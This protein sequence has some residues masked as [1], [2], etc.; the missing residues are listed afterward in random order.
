MKNTVMV[1][2]ASSLTLQ[3]MATIIIIV[4]NLCS[5]YGK[6]KLYCD[7]IKVVLCVW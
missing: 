5:L 7:S 1:R 4:I 2:L 6:V 3:A